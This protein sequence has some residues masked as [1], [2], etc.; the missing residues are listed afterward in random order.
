M[1]YMGHG[2]FDPDT[3]GVLLFTDRDGRGVA[4]SAA[5]LGVILRDHSSMRL[6]VLSPGSRRPWYAAA[7]RR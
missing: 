5:D 3:G 6:A 1:H 7:Y 4:V 2:G